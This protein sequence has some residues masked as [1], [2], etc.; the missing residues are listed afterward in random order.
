MF[1]PLGA[2]LGLAV[3]MAAGLGRDPRALPSALVGRPAPDF[4][5]STVN[6]PVREVSQAEWGG[7]ARVMN[8]WASWCA[9]CRDEHGLLLDLARDGVA[10]YG[11][12]YKDDLGAAREW[13][14]RSGDPYRQS[15]HDADGR[16]GMDFG[17]YGVPET[18]VVDARGIVRYRHAGPLTRDIVDNELMPLLRQLP[19]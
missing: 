16:V 11:L 19:P 10:L 7:R 3:L 1:V 14:A 18:F 12:N 15:L 9:A 6:E 2:L 17:I 5:L 13:L 8:V 4:K